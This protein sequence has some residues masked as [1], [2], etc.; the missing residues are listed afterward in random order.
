MFFDFFR[1]RNGLK[2]LFSA[3]GPYRG[4]QGPRTKKKP[5]VFDEDTFFE[6]ATD[7]KI[8]F[9]FSSKIFGRLGPGISLSKQVNRDFLENLG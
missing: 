9:F 8:G 1:V 7:K 6:T 4:H 3:H 2:S 5:S